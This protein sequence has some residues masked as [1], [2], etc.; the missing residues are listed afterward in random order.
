MD[1][2][3]SL[4]DISNDLFILNKHTIDRLFSSEFPSDCL[5][6]YCFYYKTAKWQKTNQVKANNEYVKKC[7]HW[8]AD[9]IQKI[10]EELKKLGLIEIVQYRKDGK[11]A[12]WFIKVNYI[13]GEKKLD[14]LVQE[15]E[16]NLSI[17]NTQI[18]EV[19]EATSSNENTN[20]L[21]YNN[22][23]LNIENKMLKN[24]NK[25]KKDFSL[26]DV[27]EEYKPLVEEWIAYKKE[28][29]KFKYKSIGLKKFYNDLKNFSNNDIS[30]AQQIIDRSI[31][32]GYSGIYPIKSNNNQSYKQN[33]D[34]YIDPLK[35]IDKI[36]WNKQQ[37]Y[38]DNLPY[39]EF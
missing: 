1:K 28:Q 18:Q 39:N 33:N 23:C 2:E 15:E 9:K 3:I 10:K 14:I 21:K 5:G 29:F 35:N 16:K 7:L 34:K 30:L 8:G 22:K 36:D 38:I 31:A 12:G 24:N 37:E 26:D 17:N 11:I 25:E 32:N 13:V 27:E 20:A 4:N 19:E 6:L